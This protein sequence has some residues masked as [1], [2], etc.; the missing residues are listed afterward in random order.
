MPKILPTR[1]K[2]PLLDIGKNSAIPC[3]NPNN[4]A[5]NKLISLAIC[6]LLVYSMYIDFNLFKILD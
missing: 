2:C 3:I 4:K 1:V 6:S 5:I